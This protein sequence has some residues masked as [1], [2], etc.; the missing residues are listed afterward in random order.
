MSKTIDERVV[1]MDFDNSK[2]EKNVQT[3]ISSLD[4]LK[5]SL[6]LDGASKGLDEVNKSAQNIDL[7]KITSG[8]TFLEKRF[9]TMGI[10][11]TTAIVKITN[12]MMDLTAKATSFL[13]NGIIQGG[14]TRAMNL[15]NARFQLEGL[16]KDENAV[17]A[18]MKNVSDSVDGTAYSLDAAA[19][20]AS[21]LAASGMQA[22]DQMFT[23]LRAVAGV[24]AMTNSEYSDIGLIF[25]QVAGQGRLMGDQLL[26]LSNRGM[27]AAAT[28]GNY[29]GKTESEVRTMVTKGEIDFQTFASAMDD[30]FGEHAKK[31]NE[32]FT[33]SL[34]NIKSALG[35]IGA[36]FVSPLIVQNG[37][38][39]QF[40][41][42]LRERINDI[43]SIIG[44][45]ATAFTDSVTKIVNAATNGL[46][47]LA[48]TGGNSWTKLS[49]KVTN[50]GVP[51][52]DFKNK[53]I[54]IAKEHGVAIDD[55]I[56]ETGSFESSLKKGWLSTSIFTETLSKFTSAN[57]QASQSTEDLNKK[58]QYFQDIVDRVWSGEFKN[59]PERYELL[60]EA[61]YD[62]E[63]VQSLVNATVDG[64]R[65]TLEDLGEEQ[66]K[67]I[68]YTDDQIKAL[69]DLKQQAEETGTPLRDLIENLTMPSDQEMLITGFKNIFEDLGK[70]LQTVKDSWDAIFNNN[71]ESSGSF[72][73]DLS[74]DFYNLTND[75]K[76]TD[77]TLGKLGNTLKGFFSAID[78]ALK[79][80]GGVFG[81]FSGF[82]KIL[83]KIFHVDFLGLTSMIADVIIKFREWILQDN[84]LVKSLTAVRDKIIDFA[85]KAVDIFISRL[86]DLCGVFKIFIDDLKLSEGISFDNIRNA[87]SNLWSNLKTYFSNFDGLINDI[88]STLAGWAGNVLD[89]FGIAGNA[90]HEFLNN[91]NWDNFIKALTEIGENIRKTFSNF[92]T[93]NDFKNIGTNI[94]TGLINGL[95]EGSEKAINTIIDIGSKLLEAIKA[96]L[97]IHS[98]STEFFNIGKNI[99]EG[100]I[101]GL[102]FMLGGLLDLIS[103]IGQKIIDTFSNIDWGVILT[104]LASSGILYVFNNFAN[105]ANKFGDALKNLTSPIASFSKLMDT[106]SGQI[107]KLGKAKAM[108][109]KADAIKS[110]AISI[111]ILAGSI[112]LLAQLDMGKAWS[113]VGMIVVL[114]AVLG[115]LTFALSKLSESVQGCDVAKTSGLL[116]SI[117]VSL[118]LLA[119]SM[120]T[121]S[122]IDQESSERARLAILE[123]GLVI[124]A[125]MK[126]VDKCDEK[127]L[128]EVKSVTLSAAGAMLLMAKAAKIM[129]SMSEDD[130]IKAGISIAAFAT[131]II[132]LISVTYLANDKK[133]SEVKS[134]TLSV[135]GAFLLMAIAA[136]MIGSMSEEDLEKGESGIWAFAAVIAALI[137]VTYLASKKQIAEVK[138]LVLSVSGAFLLMAIVAKMMGSMSVGDSIKAGIAIVAFGIV[139]AALIGVTYLASEKQLADVKSL[140]LSVSGA[141]LLMAIAAKMIGSM[142]EEDLEKGE[143]GILAFTAVVAALIFVTTKLTNEKELAKVGLTIL[144]LS[145]SI[146]ILA[147]VS[148]VLGL[149]DENNLRKG[150][151]AIGFLAAIVS[152]MVAVTQYGKNLEKLMKSIAISI[153]VM[154]A[155]IVVLSFIQPTKLAGAVAAMTILMGMFALI[156]RSSNDVNASLK[157][158]IVMMAV[159]AEITLMLTL[160][161]NIS[162]DQ[163]IE[164]AAALSVVLLT[165]AGVLKILDTIKQISNNALISIG[166]LTGVVAGIGLVLTLMTLCKPEGVIPNAIALSTVLIAM[167]AALKI[168][169]TI[170]EVSVSALVALYAL[171][172]VLTGIAG[173]FVIMG[174]LNIAP[175]LESALALS[176]VLIA[177][178]VVVTILSKIGPEAQLAIPAAWA[179]VELLGIISAV[180]LVCGAL[181]QIPGLNEFVSDGGELLETVGIAIGKFV[182]GIV[183]GAISGL[184]EG[185]LSGLPNMA[186]YLSQFMTNLN[187][188]IEGAKSLDTTVLDNVKIL[189]ELI[190]LLS[191]SEFLN[192][193]TTWLSMGT[194]PF[195]KLSD[196]LGKFG[197]AIINYSN[198][199]TEGNINLEAIRVSAEAGKA[200]T[201][202]ASTLPKGDGTSL[203]SLI[204]GKNV[205]LSDFGGQLEGFGSG[206]VKYSD[207]ISGKLDVETIKQ[208]AEAGK[209]LTDLASTLPKG[210]GDSLSSLIFGKNTSLSDFGGQLEAFGS[211]LVKYSSTIS[212]KLNVEAMNQAVEAGKALSD[213]AN[214]LP[215]DPGWL[216]KIAGG[217]DTL[218]NFGSKLSSFGKAIKDYSDS[219]VGINADSIRQSIETS[220]DFKDLF[221]SLIDF[222]YSGINN[223]NISTLSSKLK[224]YSDT[225]NDVNTESIATSVWSIQTLVSAIADMVGLDISGVESFKTAISSLAEVDLEAIAAKFGDAV[226]QFTQSGVD[227]IQALTDGFAS[228]E[229]LLVSR[230]S[231][232]ISSMAFAVQGQQGTFFTVGVTYMNAIG[233]GMSSRTTFLTSAITTL[234]F[235]MISKLNSQTASF[236]AA[237]NNLMNSFKMSISNNASNVSSS[238]DTV[239][240]TCVR[241]VNEQKW[242]MNQAGEYLGDGLVEGINGKQDAVWW[243]GFNLGK[244]AVEG[245]NKGQESDSPSK[246]MIKAGKWIGEGL[247]IGMDRMVNNVYESGKLMGET[248]VDGVSNALDKIDLLSSDLDDI[249]PAI[250]PVVDMSNMNYQMGQFQLGTNVDTLSGIQTRGIGSQTEGGTTINNRDDRTINVS[251]NYS[252]S[253]NAQ[254]MFKQLVRKLE[255]LDN[256]KG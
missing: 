247:V 206:L 94:M 200:L 167:T 84:E 55:M 39:V 51:L 50:A 88:K 163:N 237:G 53:L 48:F 209:A 251:L 162:A 248:A 179:L 149:V 63:K 227:M 5:Q 140:V 92:G 96:L 22:G 129:G 224:E 47:R 79:L 32:T 99:I 41:N 85:S 21:Q 168:L 203:S 130:L 236:T 42:T 196:Q 58:L 240:N 132:A 109:M 183:G 207:T 159:I 245:E 112:F 176:T 127:K 13:T 193:I 139:V 100:L 40:F 90:V 152:G 78:L 113:A 243:A 158:I 80:G 27:N 189:V 155:S 225:L 125:L 201:D 222:D 81:F 124:V 3:S 145:V 36:E 77:D 107:N 44:P 156:V 249:Q 136:K 76:L 120:K 74:K 231:T 119:K 14:I 46:N 86:N 215:N 223:F 252:A 169:A 114:S 108:Q 221:D 87:F 126:V 182:G 226:P 102:S 186:T 61:G 150:I 38:L 217:K 116:L 95:K 72:V 208:S 148:V 60:A 56:S 154:A 199:L 111:G 10:V 97:G 45:F 35:R 205:S 133:I 135:A 191:A 187:P 28:L 103:G 194:D 101:N 83:M 26:Q 66:L 238:M 170:N 29:L 234:T 106:L 141:F 91:M 73:H 16:L 65:L 228:G 82:V 144:A 4:K 68:G 161:S 128:S 37:P 211:G 216:N 12:S 137:G 190:A 255:M 188:F 204:F 98:P 15:E 218:E 118:I 174:S 71:N 64:H 153:G 121:L 34:A 250:S 25:T 241:A 70:I 172:P 244:K 232:L 173:A 235:A 31:A 104:V 239:I 24:A 17:S 59:A 57:S 89:Y 33:G 7:E 138:S 105:A 166:V 146:A 180:L 134:I 198:V 9:S 192:T 20:V 143:S 110:L 11:G 177:M 2:F 54:D 8:I 43:K 6:N 175:S 246:L 1:E 164:N 115:G 210:D 30:A 212:G 165:M 254:T 19:K 195:D 253:D 93:E 131:I 213:L 122:S 229:S 69:N 142:S 178:S 160:L 256:V 230:V 67:S 52:E 197:E 184:A 117:G 181:A 220:Y 75:M 185:V 219:V 202:L 242:K 49:E 123:F 147:G 62:Y 18:V 214:A 171:V 151:I 157:T 233:N 23:S